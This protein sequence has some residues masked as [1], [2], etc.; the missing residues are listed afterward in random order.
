MEINVNMDCNELQRTV[1]VA[2][3]LAVWHLQT[4]PELAVARCGGETNSENEDMLLL[5]LFT[6]LDNPIHDE[7]V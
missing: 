3:S 2:L 4:M 7:L 5:Q 1:L 6:S